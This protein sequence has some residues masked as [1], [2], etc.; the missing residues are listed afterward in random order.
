MS[1]IELLTVE[2]RFQVESLGLV[3]IPDF[4]VPSGRWRN[5]SEPVVVV[6]PD[7]N[8]FEVTA[9]FIISHFNIATTKA[10]FDDSW[11]I[12]VWLPD[13]KKEEV[14]I[15]SKILVS[16]EAREAV[17]VGNASSSPATLHDEKQ[18]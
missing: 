3:V 18:P 15:G 14:P 7:G 6:R 11:R 13:G 1:Q 9:H 10:S 16:H 8:H 12:V 2:E 17:I 4:A 5:F